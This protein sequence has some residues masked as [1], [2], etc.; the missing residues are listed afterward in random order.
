MKLLN[1]KRISRGLVPPILVLMG[2]LFGIGVANALTPSGTVITNS[3]SV[4]YE[5]GIGNTYTANSE[6]ST[7]TV[8]SV[9]AATIE[10]DELAATA[11]PNTSVNISFLLTNN[12]NADDD[13]TITFGDDSGTGTPEDVATGTAIDA[14]GYLLFIDDNQNGIAD[15]GETTVTS[16]SDITVGQNDGTTNA[17]G[18]PNN[19]AALVLQVTVPSGALD[20]QVI[21]AIL[22][23]VDADSGIIVQ[24]ITSNSNTADGQGGFDGGNGGTVD[25]GERDADGDTTADGDE[26][27]QALVTVSA[28]AVLAINKVAELDAAN[29]RITYTL[30]VTNNGAAIAN[31]IRI[32]DQIPTNSTFSEMEQI[33]L[34][35][36]AGDRFYSDGAHSGGSTDTAGYVRMTIGQDNASA[37][38]DLPGSGGNL[39][40]YYDFDD[41]GTADD[42]L[43]EEQ[44]I[45][46]GGVDLNDNGSTSDTF[47]GIEF[48]RDSLA[49]TA[50]VSIVYSVTYDPS[51]AAGT[52]I[53]NTFCVEGDLNNDASPEAVQCS[54]NVQTS[55][56]AVYGVTIDDT[57]GDAGAGPGETETTGTLGDDEDALDNNTQHE[58]TAVA[59]EVIEF[60]NVITNNG[61]IADSFELSISTGAE[62]TFPTGTTFAYFIGGSSIGSN[63]GSINAGSDVTITVQATLPT[64]LTD[65]MATLGGSATVSFDEIQNLFYIESGTNA[66]ACVAGGANDPDSD[67]CF[68]GSFGDDGVFDE[69]A[70]GA[71]N[72]DERFTAVITATSDGNAGESDTK[73]ESLGAI[74]AAI[75]D[76]TNGST[77]IDL[78]TNTDAPANLLDLVID[79]GDGVDD[80]AVNAVGGT[81]GGDAEQDIANIGSVPTAAPGD[82]VVIDLVILNE[83]GQ[84]TS[85]AVAVDTALTTIPT[86]WTVAFRPNG[87][88]A[89]FNNTP[90]PVAEGG[91]Y[92]MEAVITVSSNVAEA[93]AGD[94]DFAFKITSN[95]DATV[96]D[97]KVDRITVTAVCNITEGAGA[98]DQ[99][100][101]NGTVDYSHT[102]TNNG[103]QPQTLDLSAALSIVSAGANGL[104]GWSATI[105]IDTTGNGS[106]NEDYANLNIGSGDG[107]G[108][109]DTDD[110]ITISDASAAGALTVI[111]T[112]NDGSGNVA[113]TLDP[114]DSISFEVRV[115]APSTAAANDKIRTTITIDG[116]CEAAAII[117]DS[118]V[119]LQV[120]IDKTVAVDPNCTC[121]EA[122]SG[123]SAFA[124]NNATAVNPGE[125]L[126]WRLTVTNDGTETAQEVSIT[127]QITPFSVAISSGVWGASNPS[128]VTGPPADAQIH[129]T[130][131]SENAVGS[132]CQLTANIGDATPTGTDTVVISGSSVTFN[133]GSGADDTT[134]GTLIGSDSAVGQFC[135]QVQ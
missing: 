122:G 53:Q 98:S 132:S 130:C 91:S 113:F 10:T 78:N 134:G 71:G 64:T 21:G 42:F 80:K 49:P 128:G 17:F 60:D 67:G 19:V 50:S 69:T 124:Q 56:P 63:T 65:G 38:Y 125:C 88:G 93:D 105:R 77:T 28:D 114:G 115:F 18:F 11:A 43:I 123:V 84:S 106:V 32:V 13:F 120:R 129:Q 100:Q 55:I 5:D 75:I 90:S 12:G 127:D 118:T 59:G 68:D 116:G 1:L 94:Y 126:I 82:T 89:T 52:L 8:G 7:V 85:F 70:T 86:G 16:G 101:K 95:A 117:D 40:F 111:E 83:Q 110:E 97:T 96:T 81:D 54:N 74:K 104:T 20:T 135:V 33:N 25:A 108:G 37:P 87:G 6:D 31:D 14:T 15:G 45:V 3:A 2:S 51:L 35:T 99:I 48:L 57:D 112:E 66:T 44:S 58:A 121:D 30:N 22:T 29:N 36:A 9:F 119:G 24:D 102:I 73:I 133:V 79:D 41:D 109:A 131:L 76:L 4:D 46:E 107:V 103:N 23:A 62:N 39:E 34:S 27:V 92:L 47:D 26:S 61:N 72:D